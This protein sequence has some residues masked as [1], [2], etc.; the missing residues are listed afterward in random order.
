MANLLETYKSRLAVAD[1]I[2]AKTHNG[3]RLDS[4]KKLFI[5]KCLDNT[6]WPYGPVALVG[7]Y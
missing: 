7:D 1:Q 6:N 4:T 2:H 3:Q 5:A